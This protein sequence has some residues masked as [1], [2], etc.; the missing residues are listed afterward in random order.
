PVY[1]I[2]LGTLYAQTKNE[3]AL[4][5]ADGL[6]YAKDPYAERHAYFIKGLYY[7]YSGQKENAI[8]FFDKCLTMSYTD[9]DA[10]LEKS[11]ALYD[12][13]KYKAALET[14]DK[15]LLLQNNFETGHYYRGKYL[16]KL[17]RRPEATDAYKMALM[18]D[19]AYIE[20]AEALAKLG[21]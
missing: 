14:I 16:E 11:I 21:G 15:A 17:N 8:Q 2:A 1:V 12:L 19:P 5:M 18:Y 6:L 3:T 9:M 4:T 10:Y 7:T 13:G 20:A